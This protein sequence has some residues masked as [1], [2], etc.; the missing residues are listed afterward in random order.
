MIINKFY[1][2]EGKINTL[3]DIL[4]VVDLESSR[5][6]EKSKKLYEELSQTEINI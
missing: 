6:S 4:K 3:L 1:T 2:T 5:F